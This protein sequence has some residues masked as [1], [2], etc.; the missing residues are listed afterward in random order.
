M[1]SH[2]LRLCQVCQPGLYAINKPLHFSSS[3]LAPDLT[4]LKQSSLMLL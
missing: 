3:R 1:M 2:L 4:T